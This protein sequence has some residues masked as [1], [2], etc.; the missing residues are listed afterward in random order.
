MRYRSRLVRLDNFIRKLKWRASHRGATHTVPVYIFGAQSSGTTMLDLCLGASPECENL[1]EIDRRAFQDYSLREI[2]VIERLIAECPY[3]F[4]IFKPLKDSHRV[5]ELLALRPDA[6]AVWAF[7]NFADRINSAL[8]KRFKRRPLEILAAFRNGDWE[9]WQFQGMS[10][11]TAETLLR[12]DLD[13]TSQSDA[14][15]LMWWVRNSLYFDQG[16][17]RDPRVRL[18]SYDRFVR[19]PEP[20]LRALLAHLGAE[21][22]PHMLRGVHA[23]SIGKHPAPRINGR[24]LELCDAMLE[25]LEAARMAGDASNGARL[26][27]PS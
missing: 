16:L 19:A 11:E 12:C 8:H 10:P 5:R 13:E 14:A 26:A 7:R 25:R 1:G 18:W 17:D 6:K 23:Q 2:S 20:E 24:I 9:H 22:H 27:R 15:A 3:R 4:L 21:F